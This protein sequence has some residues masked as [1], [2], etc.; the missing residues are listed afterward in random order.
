MCALLESSIYGQPIGQQENQGDK[1]NTVKPVPP[2]APPAL[3]GI[4]DVLACQQAVRLGVLVLLAEATVVERLAWLRHCGNV[5]ATPVDQQ[6]RAM[7]VLHRLLIIQMALIIGHQIDAAYWHEWD[8]FHMPGGIQLFNAIN[9]M[10]FLILLVCLQWA[11]SGHPRG[12]VGAWVVTVGGGLILPIH[13][14]FALAG[15]QQFA[16]PVSVALIVAS[17][18]STLALVMLLSRRQA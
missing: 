13:A 11:F 18:L 14:G 3:I 4:T 7:S 16:L 8:M 2:F 17:F 6:W 1:D 5:A 12:R 9:V 10:L 15:Y